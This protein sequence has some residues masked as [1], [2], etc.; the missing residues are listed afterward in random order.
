MTI[1]QKQRML[2]FLTDGQG[3]PYYSGQ[4]D[5]KWGPKS[6]AAQEK[7]LA[8]FGVS[9]AAAEAPAAELPDWAS[10]NTVMVFSLAA[11]GE[12][13]L[14][15]NFKVKEFACKDGSDPVFIHPSVPMWCQAVRDTFGYAFRPNSAYRTV[16]YNAGIKDASPKSKHC[17][18]LAVDIPAKDGT[19]PQQLYDFFEDLL[20]DTGGLGLYSWGVHVDP[21]PVKSRWKG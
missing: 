13:Q 7:F 21:R 17:L 10:E 20:G 11:D 6:E 12:K 3:V 1:E 8:D 5:G 15:P 4:I 19:T 16:S 9:L 2:A 18:G 14:T